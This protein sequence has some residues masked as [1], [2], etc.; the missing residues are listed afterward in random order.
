M[1]RNRIAFLRCSRN[2]HL[3]SSKRMAVVTDF[4]TPIG[5]GAFSTIRNRAWLRQ[6]VRMCILP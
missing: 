4:D 3:S 1:L 5:I 6:T 2:A